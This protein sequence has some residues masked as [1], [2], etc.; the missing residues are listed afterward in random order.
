MT[1]FQRMKKK[2]H[3]EFSQK[4]FYMKTSSSS[5]PAAGKGL[6]AGIRKGADMAPAAA[7]DYG[8]G[9][10]VNHVKFGE[11]TVKEIREGGRD[12]EVT[13]EFDRF[14]VKKMF[15]TFAKLK[16]LDS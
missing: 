4:P 15:A 11:G 13:V 2:E 10:R 5:R 7:L 3:E 8:E 6:S 1:R 14:G 12:R 16:K 9:D